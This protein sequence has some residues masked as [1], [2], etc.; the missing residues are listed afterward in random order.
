MENN[1][2][3]ADDS[4]KLKSVFINMGLAAAGLIFALVLGELFLRAFFPLSRVSDPILGYRGNPGV[5]WDENGFRNESALNKADIVALGD[6][7]TEGFNAEMNEAWPQ[8]L[9]NLSGKTVYNMGFG[10]YGPAQYYYLTEEALSLEPD[11]IIVGF[12]LGNDLANAFDAVYQNDNWRAF[13]DPSFNAS[14][15]AAT[16]RPFDEKN[17]ETLMLQFGYVPNFW[18]M[19]ILK[20]RLWL[21][22]HSRLYSFLGD[23]TRQ[24]REKLKLVRGNDDMNK[25]IEEYL[26]NNQNIGFVYDAGNIKTILS[27]ADRLE[28]VNIKNGKTGEGY[29]ITKD[30]FS[31]MDRQLKDKDKKLIIAVIPTKELVYGT[32]FKKVDAMG[33]VDVSFWELLKQETELKDDFLNFCKNNRLLCIDTSAF[34]V[35]GLRDN[36]KLYSE[37]LESHPI[38]GG[39]QMIAEAIFNYLKEEKIFV[40][41]KY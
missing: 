27:I 36:V 3:V 41:S 32:Y 29:R 14:G 9:S 21:R 25:G 34:Q 10:G 12:Y 6:S 1:S 18:Q 37:T 38:G 8:A 17:N 13:R 20:T 33:D 4:K 16:N 2:F 5:R 19:K 40:T 23:S 15:T 28:T 30:L 7:L 22:D 39:Y 26:I 24:L 11:L 35:N 31:E